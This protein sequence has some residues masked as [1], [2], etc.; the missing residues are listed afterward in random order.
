MD[1]FSAGEKRGGSPKRIIRS[2]NEKLVAF[3]HQR[4]D[5]D[6][7]HFRG[8]VADVNMFLIKSEQP[9]GLI[10][11]NDR[12]SRREY[13]FRMAV[14]FRILQIHTDIPNYLIRRVQSECRRIAGIELHDIH[15]VRDHFVCP[16]DYRTADIVTDIVQFMRFI[17]LSHFRLLSPA[18]RLFR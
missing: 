16:F 17:K 13:P 2:G 1:R 6:G 12:L 7:Y 10:I 11:L 9:F 5:T 8:S 3:V 4:L 14:A 18:A 15:S